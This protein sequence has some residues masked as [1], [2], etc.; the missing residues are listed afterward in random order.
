M[1]NL[2][3]DE[4]RKS[5]I[6][7]LR[8]KCKSGSGEFVK[9]SGRIHT[10]LK[11]SRNKGGIEVLKMSWDLIGKMYLV[12]F[13][14]PYIPELIAALMHFALI[15]EDGMYRVDIAKVP[16]PRENP[17]PLPKSFENVGIRWA[18][19][20]WLDEEPAFPPMWWKDPTI[21]YRDPIRIYR[22]DW[23]EV[24]ERLFAFER[25]MRNSVKLAS[26]TSED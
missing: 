5:I 19:W 6:G 14:A 2:E 18:W 7:A 10:M 4:H 23:E 3:K 20:T 8:Q 26:M 11:F 25:C 22:A 1:A 12:N 9:P 16:V 21:H 17:P 13:E 24:V 15:W